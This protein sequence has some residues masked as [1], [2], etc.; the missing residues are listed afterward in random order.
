MTHML[1]SW[2]FSWPSPIISS[3]PLCQGNSW[4]RLVLQ[5]MHQTWSVDDG[6]KG[7]GGLV[8]G[9]RNPTFE[10]LSQATLTAGKFTLCLQVWTL[11]FIHDLFQQRQGRACREFEDTI[12]VQVAIPAH[13]SDAAC[14]VLVFLLLNR[15]L[16]VWKYSLA[17]ALSGR[18]WHT[19]HTRV[20]DCYKKGKIKSPFCPHL[21]WPFRSIRCPNQ[22]LTITWTPRPGPWRHQVFWTCC[23]RWLQ[24]WHQKRSQ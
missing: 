21:T 22:H 23:L 1:Y 14:F 2:S 7:G 19:G 5:T 24:T 12:Q 10:P 15:S 3:F 8:G 20:C 16:R 11:F 17:R 4:W 18:K 13:V 9:E 6:R